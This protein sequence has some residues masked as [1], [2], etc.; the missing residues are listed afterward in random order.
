MAEAVG[1]CSRSVYL[2]TYCQ[3]DTEKVESRLQFNDM[4]LESFRR[5]CVEMV[6]RTF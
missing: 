4:L 3:A 6:K 1:P 5:I 2:I